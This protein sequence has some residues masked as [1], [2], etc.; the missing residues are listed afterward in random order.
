[1]AIWTNVSVEAFYRVNKMDV[2]TN[3]DIV[4][5]YDID[6]VYVTGIPSKGNEGLWIDGIKIKIETD[7]DRLGILGE[8]FRQT[9]RRTIIGNVRLFIH[10]YVFHGILLTVDVRDD[11]VRIGHDIWRDCSVISNDLEGTFMDACILVTV[12]HALIEEIH[13]LFDI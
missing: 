4:V 3:Y 8:V 9:F 6:N 10:A 11:Y 5:I 7:G 13:V 1:M 12:T 2:R